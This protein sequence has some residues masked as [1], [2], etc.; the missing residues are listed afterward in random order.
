M[1]R[2]GLSF[3]V[4]DQESDQRFVGAAVC[5]PWLL[6][7]WNGVDRAPWLLHDD[8]RDVE[9]QQQHINGL[10]LL[11]LVAVVLDVWR[12]DPQGPTSLILHR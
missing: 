9:K 6:A 4:I 12:A 8:L 2:S 7:I 1:T 10:E 5:P 11:A 3:V